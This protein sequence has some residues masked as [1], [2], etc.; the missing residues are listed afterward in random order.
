MT[1]QPSADGP[2][3]T[4]IVRAA[5]SRLLIDLVAASGA[6]ALVSVVTK[7]VAA[8]ASLPK[9]DGLAVFTVLGVPV[10]IGVYVGLVRLLERRRAT[11]L[12][13][14]GVLRELGTG[15][16]IGAGLFATVIG[17]IALFGGYSIAGTESPSVLVAPIAM[18]VE[19]GFVEEILMR[20]ILFRLLEEWLGT[21]AALA[22]SA[23]LFGFGHIGNPHATIWSAVAIA[24]EA[25]TML[26]AAYMVT[27]RLW[28]AIGIHAAWNY[29]QGPI[30]GVAVSGFEMKGLFRGTMHGKSWLT[31]GEFGAEASAVA[32]FVCSGAAAYLL[33]RALR[34]G[35]AM[36]PSW[37]RK[38]RAAAAAA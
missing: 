3:W 24:V 14:P 16:L 15:L 31:G 19:S 8:A 7:R 33:A 11:E 9:E 2:L 38:R 22:I 12:A 25:G 35:G 23:A 1:N 26:A 20:G 13:G 29:T 10:L 18:A 30:F 17:I 34:S 5:P 27:R 36:A 6:L 37:V 28:L 32:V 21:W 4:R